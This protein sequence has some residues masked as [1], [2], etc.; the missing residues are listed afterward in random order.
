MML[1]QV[2]SYFF[3]LLARE[4]SSFRRRDRPSWPAELLSTSAVVPPLIRNSSQ[5]SDASIYFNTVVAVGESN[6]GRQRASLRAMGEKNRTRTAIS[7]GKNTVHGESSTNGGSRT[8]NGAR[9][10]G[11]LPPVP[12]S[13]GGKE[14]P[15]NPSGRIALRKPRKRQGKEFV[16]IALGDVNYLTIVPFEIINRKSKH[17]CCVVTRDYRAYKR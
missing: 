13:L 4:Q 7:W 12:A 14:Q 3:L 10:R 17:W 11:S 16:S 9:K 2:G 5:D 1:Y 8:S 15:N 6:F